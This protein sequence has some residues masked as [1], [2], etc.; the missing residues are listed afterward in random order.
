MFIAWDSMGADGSAFG[1]GGRILNNRGEPDGPEFLINE[2]GANDQSFSHVVRLIDGGVLVVWQSQ[3][4]DADHEG[5]WGI[6]GQLFDVDGIKVGGEFQVNSHAEGDQRLPQV[7]AMP[8]SGFFVAWMTDGQIASGMDVVGQR[9]D[10]QGQPAGAELFI[11]VVTN[12]YQRNPSPAALKDGSVVVAF[13]ADDWDGSRFGVFRR[14]LVF[15]GLALETMVGKVGGDT[16]VFE[17]PFSARDITGFDPSID[18]IDVSAF[19]TE[20]AAIT[21]LSESPNLIIDTGNGL[22]RLLGVDELQAD[23]FLF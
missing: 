11:N 13:H 20:F 21:F 12:S 14:R 18:R 23:H 10:A 1:I 15:S 19:A 7:T 2:Y 16:F 22:I 5:G 17:V 4:Q 3:G 9:F 6:F 8:D